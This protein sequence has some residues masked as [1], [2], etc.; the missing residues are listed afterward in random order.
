MHL[1][2]DVM[3]H[4]LCGVLSQDW[5]HDV[6]TRLGSH[7]YPSQILKLKVWTTDPQTHLSSSRN[8]QNPGY[9]SGLEWRQHSMKGL[10][11]S[12]VWCLD[13]GGGTRGAGEVRAVTV[14]RDAVQSEPLTRGR[15]VCFPLSPEDRWSVHSEVWVIYGSLWIRL[16]RHCRVTCWTWRSFFCLTKRNVAIHLVLDILLN[17]SFKLH[18]A[19]CVCFPEQMAPSTRSCEWTSQWTTAPSSSPGRWRTPWR[20]RQGSCTS[21]RSLSARPPL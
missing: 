15:M 11:T 6:S 13:H 17:R 18:F 14:P 16:Y 20:T 5:S 10:A 21:P 3:N 1:I 9:T 7:W 12:F 4:A 8:S 19:V 2:V